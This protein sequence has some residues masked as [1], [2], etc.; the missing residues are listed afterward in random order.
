V[1]VEI[2]MW[3]VGAALLPACGWA[4]HITWQVNRL[5]DQHN[6]PDKT[7]FGTKFLEPVPAAISAV[8][9]SQE[10]LQ[11]VIEANTVA[12]KDNTEAFRELKMMIQYKNSD[13][14]SFDQN[15]M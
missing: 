11:K 14:G 6:D 3:V 10:Q 15:A 7:G 1:N 13:S 2:A 5:V 9:A 4:V 12:I 8:Q